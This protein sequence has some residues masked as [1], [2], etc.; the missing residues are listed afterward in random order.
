MN[1]YCIP[2]PPL[3]GD[4]ASSECV[5]PT[6]HVKASGVVIEELSTLTNPE[7]VGSE[8]IV[9][10]TVA[11]LTVIGELV[12]DTVPHVTVMVWEPAVFKMKPVPA[13]V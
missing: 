1:T 9:I 10:E 3:T 11:G 4:K 8:V 6:V 13:N 5:E 12:K 2:L 7:P